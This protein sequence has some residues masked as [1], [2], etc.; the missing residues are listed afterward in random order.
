MD[1]SVREPKKII[2]VLMYEAKLGREH[3]TTC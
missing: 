1:A 3:I 2:F